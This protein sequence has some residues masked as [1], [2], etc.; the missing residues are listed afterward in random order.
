MVG[1][2]TQDKSVST[3]E[4]TV[5]IGGRAPTDDRWPADAASRIE[6]AAAALEL[7]DIVDFE[8]VLMSSL[9]EIAEIF[10][11]AALGECTGVPGEGVTWFD[12]TATSLDELVAM[13]DDLEESAPVADGPYSIVGPSGR[14]AIGVPNPPGSFAHYFAV[15]A[16]DPTGFSAEQTSLL[17]LFASTVSSAR[18]RVE[19]T[20]LLEARLANQEFLNDISALAAGDSD[21]TLREIAIAAQ[22]QYD[23]AA[24]TM[25]RFEDLHAHLAVSSSDDDLHSVGVLAVPVTAAQVEQLRADGWG[26]ANVGDFSGSQPFRH[27]PGADLLVVPMM[28]AHGAE[29]AVVFTASTS[30]SWSEIEVA[31]AQSIARSMQ[32]VLGRRRA[33]AAVAS[34]VD[35]ERVL[36]SIAGLAGG[37]KHEAEPAVLTLSRLMSS[38]FVSSSATIVCR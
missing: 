1:R 34:S 18:R 6:A 33:A 27:G 12:D 38:A 11:V 23:V 16:A 4:I 36:R 14:P 17:S 3:D 29:G 28:G 31:G 19:A 37:A 5:M 20:R 15:L 24:V 30:G 2:A 32:K 9:A 26:T 13:I 25:W 21:D 22:T 35:G 10:G 8:A 7:C